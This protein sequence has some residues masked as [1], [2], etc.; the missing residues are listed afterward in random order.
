MRV[1]SILLLLLLT[2]TGCGSQQPPSEPS[3][4]EEMAV[5]AVIVPETTAAA[6]PV[7]EMLASMSLREKVGQLFIVRPEALD[8]ALEACKEL[9]DGIR[10]GLI[11]YPV[12][13]F[14]L[15][16]ENLSS[17][18]QVTGLNAALQSACTIPPFLAVDEEGGLV[19]RL[20]NHKAFSL[21]KF[22]SAA[23]IPGPDQAREMGRTIGAYLREYGF[24]MDFAPVADVNT[25]P[26]NPVIGTRA[27]SSD[28]A[29]AGQMAAAMAEGLRENGIIPTFKH[30]PG[31]GDTDEDSHAKIAVSHKTQAELTDCEFIPFTWTLSTDC[32]M[33]GHIALPEITG[34]LAPATLSRLIVTG[35]LKDQLGFQGLVIT[36]ALDMEAITGT[37]TAAEAAVLALQA[38][39]DLL[40]MPENLT[41]AFE[42][43]VAAVEDGRLKERWLEETVRRVL[44]FKMAHGILVI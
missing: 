27:F 7:E 26:D 33:V 19:S 1:L 4:P 21:P 8:P 9:N 6:D 36:D 41:E 31:H 42:G 16:Y 14:V 25:N 3:A 29:I 38:G 40:L 22:D 2:I 18:E 12:G 20:A 15:F 13:G 39:C 28:P 37:Y 23:S 24:N 44:E 32:I 5:P 10:N 11:Q 34:T 17:P 30:F 43:V 35:L